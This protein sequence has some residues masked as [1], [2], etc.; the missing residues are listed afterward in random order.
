MDLNFNL[1]A[2][3]VGESR[4]GLAT[5]N[6]IAKMASPLKTIQQTDDILDDI[7]QIISTEN[8]RVVVVGLPRSLS[9]DETSQTK[10]S[11]DFS[12]KL[13]DKT[14][15]HIFMEDEALSSVRAKEYLAQQNKNYKK[16]DIDSV[17]ASFILNDF[18]LNHPEV[19]NG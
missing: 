13:S 17:A 2:L 18:M 3:D 19:F 7:Q 4:V 9:G 1:L 15:L 12:K 6:S 11:K 5:A 10:F 14:G 8:V 16:E